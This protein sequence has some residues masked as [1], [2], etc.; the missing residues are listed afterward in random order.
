MAINT[1][2][3]PNAVAR[4]RSLGAAYAATDNG[5][6]IKVQGG[7]FD[8]NLVLDRNMATTIKG[9]YDSS[10][11][12]QGSTTILRSLIISQGSVTIDNIILN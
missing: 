5:G 1:F 9:G 8:E 11:T 7:L 3:Q 4:G 12:N 2:A 10:F 6:L